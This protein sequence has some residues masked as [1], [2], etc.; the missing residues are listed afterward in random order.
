MGVVTTGVQKPNTGVIPGL[1]ENGQTVSEAAQHTRK[2]N[3]SRIA[4]GDTILIEVESSS[5]HDFI[6]D[7]LSSSIIDYTSLGTVVSMLGHASKAAGIWT[8][9][10][11]LSTGGNPDGD[12]IVTVNGGAISL[13]QLVAD[14]LESRPFVS[15]IK[16]VANTANDQVQFQKVFG[17]IE[18]PRGQQANVVPLTG[19]I[20]KADTGSV[21]AASTRWFV[22]NPNSTDGKEWSKY[23][24]FYFVAGAGLGYSM[25]FTTPIHGRI[26]H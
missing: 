3:N 14:I 5:A 9:T 18:Q 26:A 11:P 16:M 4:F 2:R 12:L 21:D 8:S 17:Y 19:V 23:R 10:I 13:D 25:E 1:K 7:F 20:K 15:D 22:P 6:F 24:D